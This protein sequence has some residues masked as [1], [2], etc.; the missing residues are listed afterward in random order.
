ML[1]YTKM[2][3]Y[4]CG[5][6][7]SL[8]EQTTCKCN[9]CSQYY[10]MKHRLMEAHTCSYDWREKKTEEVQKYIETNKCVNS[11]LVKI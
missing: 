11:K 4:V 9:K 2:T 5:K 8:I 6:K 7:I 3:C 1:L 10:C